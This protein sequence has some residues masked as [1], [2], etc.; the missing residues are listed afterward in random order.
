MVKLAPTQ[1]VKLTHSRLAILVIGL[2]GLVMGTLFAGTTSAARAG[3][4]RASNPAL[5]R[6]LQELVSMPGGPAGAIAIVQRG[7]SAIVY[8]AGVGDLQTKQPIQATDHM[9]VASVAKAYSGAVALALVQRGRLSLDDTI[10]RWLPWLPRAWWRVTLRQALDHT[11]GLPD[12]T[13]STVWVNAF[14]A[15]PRSTPPP[16][17]LLASLIRTPLVF[18]PGVRFAYSNTDNIV[19]GL[20]VQAA[21]SRS[22]ADQLNSLVLRPLHL[23]QTS[24]PVGYQMPSP[25]L[26]GY[27]YPGPTRD[28]LSTV[29]SAA[30][31][32][33]SGGVVST[34]SD[35]NRFIRGYVG[36]ALFSRQ[37]Q[38][39]QL[40]FVAGDSEPIGPGTNSAGLGIFRYYT[41]CGTMYG[42]TGNVYG[43]TQFG[44]STLNGRT[45][46]TVS[47]SEQ[48]NQHD[49]GQRLRVFTRL[50]AADETAVCAAL[51]GAG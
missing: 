10:G 27:D 34:P 13:G 22:F 19:V 39:Q 44:A 6:A 33:T 41:R 38:S 49:T 32:W 2:V 26:H 16:P 17:W 11:S 30:W 14:L 9:R 29:A 7:S 45:S 23:R 18:K 35:L 12:Y 3:S 25:Y 50:R 51:R 28:D 1:T 40:R 37:V 48:L 36:R 5:V 47:V 8:R 21:T 20:M 43:Y 46:V 42:H 24:L 4:A 15:A 31:L